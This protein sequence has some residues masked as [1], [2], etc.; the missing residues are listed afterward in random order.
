MYNHKCNI[1][2]KI[3]SYNCQVVRFRQKKKNPK[4]TKKQDT[5]KFEYKI[6]VGNDFSVYIKIYL[7]YTHTI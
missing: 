3:A 7:E 1:K 4:Q 5:V 6:N 2:I